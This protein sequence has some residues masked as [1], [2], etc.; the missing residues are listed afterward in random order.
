MFVELFEKFKKNDGLR[1]FAV[2]LVILLVL[3]LI[4]DIISLILLTFIL[5][6]LITRVVS[7]L[8]KW[9]KLPKKILAIMLY[10]LIVVFMYFS[11]TIYV[12]RLINQTFS[13]VESVINFYQNPKTDNSLVE[14]LSKKISFSEITDQLKSGAKML[15]TYVTSVGSMGMTFLMSFILSFFFC[16]EEN[17]VKDFSK[18]FLTSKIGCFSQDVAYLGKKFINTFGVVLE[19]QFLIALV[20]TA[21]TTIGLSL[22]GFPQLLSLALMIFI[23]SLIPV[24]GVIISCI[25]LA[26]IGYTVGGIQDVV[27]V[28]IMIAVIHMFESY[29]LNPKL[30]SS[31][32]DLPVFYIFIIL[33]FSE[34]FFGVWG[35][36]IG[37]PVFVFLLDLLDVKSS[38]RQKLP[39]L[40]ISKN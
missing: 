13:M 8:N 38:D 14:W 29:F 39:K 36:V 22:M 2:L 3:Y 26:L 12:P 16:L 27:Y 33:M 9:I 28:L 40:P 20:N 6:Y 23:F 30:M 35:L 31:K 24:A 4:R 34:H 5:T 7:V 21:L 15:V 18:S 25:P 11:I 19:A 1:R 37:I 10:I 32:T 17:W